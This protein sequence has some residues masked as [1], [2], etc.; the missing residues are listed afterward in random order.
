[1]Q[2]LLVVSWVQVCTWPTLSVCYFSTVN[3]SDDKSAKQLLKNNELMEK[4]GLYVEGPF[5]DFPQNIIQCTVVMNYM[6][7]QSWYV[8]AG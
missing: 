8:N 7:I 2:N 5:R 3:I 4:V 1:M 6:T